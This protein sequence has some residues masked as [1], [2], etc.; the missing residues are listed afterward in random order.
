MRR[1]DVVS[2]YRSV[3]GFTLVEMLAV[4]LIIAVMMGIGL[5][6]LSNT[7]ADLN[8]KSAAGEILSILRG[9]RMRAIEES[10]PVKLIFDT[11]ERTVTALV[12]EPVSMWHFEDIR[13]GATS[14][15][16]GRNGSIENGVA[17]DGKTGRALRLSSKG[18]VDCGAIPLIVPDQGIAVSFWI[19]REEEGKNQIVC[20]LGKGFAVG[21]DKNGLV[22]VKVGNETF[23]P[24]GGGA[25]VR[26]RTWTRVSFSN[27]RGRSRLE[28]S[29]FSTSGDSGETSPKWHSNESPFMIGDREQGFVGLID[30][31]K[32][33]VIVPQEPVA[34][35]V[36]VDFDIPRELID[37]QGR[38]QIVFDAAGRLD[39]GYHSRDISLGV[40]SGSEKIPMTIRTDGTTVR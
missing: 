15:G 23:P 36:G 28:V 30:E 37:Q 24:A 8:I 25:C 12:T 29:E 10:N 4:L 11:K 16:F 38:T 1:D 32:I 27:D 20:A 2:G 14:G 34:L 19:Y 3:A 35:P 13:N 31:F 21:L 6:V 22:V 17:A 18:F 26:L 33:G 7:G 40:K 9:A 39:R 5:A